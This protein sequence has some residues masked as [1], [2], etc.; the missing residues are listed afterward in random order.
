MRHRSVTLVLAATISLLVGAPALPALADDPVTLTVTGLPDET[1]GTTSLGD[2]WGA[3]LVLGV[4]PSDPAVASIRVTATPWG[5]DEVLIAEDDSAPF[6]I[7]WVPSQTLEPGRFVL[8][9]WAYDAN[10]TLLA[11]AGRG[12]VI[13]APRPT[14]QVW[15]GLESSPTTH[16]LDPASAFVSW[17]LNLPESTSYRSAV[18]RLDGAVVYTWLPWGEVPSDS[19]GLSSGQS[20]VIDPARVPVGKHRWDVTV[21]DWAGYVTTGS[22]T[23]WVD[24]PASLAP[25]S[26]TDAAGRPV[27]SSTWVLAGSTLRVRTS[28]TTSP[29]FDLGVTEWSVQAD[30]GNGTVPALAGLNNP[31]DMARYPCLT[32]PTKCPAPIWINRT[33]TVGTWAHTSTAH[34][35]AYAQAGGV[36]VEASASYRLYP[37]STSV[38]R[39]SARTANAG[40]TVTL[41]GRL[42][43]VQAGTG[44]ADQPGI[45]GE[46]MVL[47]RRLA[48]S[49]T[50]TTVTAVKTP[51]SGYVTAT[52]HASHNAQY[53]WYHADHV[54]SAGPSTS[55]AI[56]VNA[57]PAVSV[58]VLTTAPSAR[59]ATS[60]RIASSKPQAG[61][62]LTLQR[63]TGSAW[64]TIA[65]ARQGSTGTAT[66]RVTLPAGTVKLRAVAAATVAYAQGT[67]AVTVVVVRR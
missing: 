59:S 3:G 30:E 67:S 11:V 8:N 32:T 53:R 28:I 12:R 6:E 15:N 7:P 10:G 34:V 17:R 1:S 21:T 20:P 35:D 29:A 14:L 47:Q 58:T 18:A 33:W 66:V 22:A 54:G 40:S 62:T 19:F 50:W 48:E 26:I 52:F 25:L 41:S 65:T 60:V 44:L 43:R 55:A 39:S 57:R 45:G 42:T 4:E 64:K 5:G 16:E 24:T 23:F 27:T 37:Q 9:V 49:T 56:T 51:S 38:M 61:A 2:L 46:V 31:A 13:G 36:P 63:W